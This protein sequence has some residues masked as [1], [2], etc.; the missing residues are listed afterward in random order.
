MENIFTPTYLHSESQYISS[1]VYISVI[2]FEMKGNTGATHA[3]INC[4]IQY[5]IEGVNGVHF[6]TVL[7]TL[8][9]RYSISSASL[10][11][12]W[13]LVKLFPN[14]ADF[15]THK[16]CYNCL[17]GESMLHRARVGHLLLKVLLLFFSSSLHFPFYNYVDDGNGQYWLKQPLGLLRSQGT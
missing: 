17:L 8:S 7:N 15:P 16:I 14:K 5:L 9:G 3:I 12:L 2:R 4:H 11:F 10:I 13:I 1:V 6:H